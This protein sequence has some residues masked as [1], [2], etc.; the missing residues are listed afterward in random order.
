MPK[1]VYISWDLSCL[2]A[3]YMWFK[4]CWGYHF[5]IRCI[6]RWGYLLAF[7][8]CCLAILKVFNYS[9]DSKHMVWITS[10]WNACLCKIISSYLRWMHMT[11]MVQWVWWRVSASQFPFLRLSIIFSN[12]KWMIDWIYVSYIS[13]ESWIPLWVHLITSVLFVAKF[14]K[15][16]LKSKATYFI[17]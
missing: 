10:K 1:A 7:L 13:V 4:Q 2:K 14:P 15:C 11:Y 8:K 6:D 17:K 3:I 9:L 5:S 16:W 12:G